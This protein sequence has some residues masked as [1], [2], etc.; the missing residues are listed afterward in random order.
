MSSPDDLRHVS[1]W[2]AKQKIGRVVWGILQATLFRC[3]PHP[4]YTWR[5]MLL[6]MFGAKLAKQVR[7]RRTVRIEIPWNLEV[8]AHTAIGDFAIIYNLG[9]IKLG[10]YV[11]VSQ[12]AHLCALTH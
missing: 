3:S 7:I 5:A 9:P 11:T 6:R 10:Q 12:H 1:P 2:T 4:A 8:G